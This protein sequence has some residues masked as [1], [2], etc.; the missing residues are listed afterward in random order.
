M[1]QI[2]NV[3][4]GYGMTPNV[5]DQISSQVDVVSRFL[6]IVGSFPPSKQTI[7]LPHQ[8]VQDPNTW[9]LSHLLQLKQEF[10]NL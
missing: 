8:N 7:C 9:T 3:M 1:I 6:D 10:D 2:P 4:R 5:I